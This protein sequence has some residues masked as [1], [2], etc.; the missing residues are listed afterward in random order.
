MKTTNAYRILA[1][2]AALLL[3]ACEAEHD[4]AE[5]QHTGG[6]DTDTDVDSDADSDSDADGDI[7]GCGGVDF[8]FVVDNSISMGD[9]QQNLID[10]F[11]GFIQAITETLDLDDFHIM[12]VDSDASYGNVSSL[13]QTQCGTP[14]CCE[15]WCL[16]ALPTD[17]C[18]EDT[19][20]PYQTCSEWLGD[21]AGGCHDELG[22]GHTGDNLGVECPIDGDNRYLVQ[23]QSDLEE[24]FACIADVGV[25]GN[26]LEKLMEA[27][28]NAIGPLDADDGCN[29]GFIREEAILVYTF[30][31]DED[32]ACTDLGEECSAGDPATWKQALV[33]AKGGDEDS[34][35]VLGV[36][37]DNDLADG[38]CDPY[39]PDMGQ[40]AMAAPLLRD[41][42]D[43]FGDHG[44][45]CSV[46][47][48]DYNDC[49]L[50]AVSTIDTT[51]E[52]YDPP[53]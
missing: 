35:V 24:T 21:E 36:F 49:F 5:D 6:G 42:V 47:L 17:Q 7:E 12:A 4:V 40:G 13:T 30:V 10:S 39:D 18:K 27:M 25:E 52:E 1:L 44:H 8:L 15:D 2:C 45:Y 19:A 34:V 53:E 31:T 20:D 50:E 22:A 16:T 43:S 28:T 23:G 46:C 33:D 26:G 11:P 32:E 48:P 14:G 51:C 38:I 29:A 3:V 41:F 37:G 9:E